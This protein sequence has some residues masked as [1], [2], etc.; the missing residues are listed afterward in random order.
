MSQ[1]TNA[2]TCHVEWSERSAFSSTCEEKIS[3]LWLEMANA[4]QSPSG[5]QTSSSEAQRSGFAG[6]HRRAVGIVD[7][8][9]AVFFQHGFDSIRVANRD[10]LQRI[11]I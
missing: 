5:K 9:R 4:T 2:H 1:C 6:T 8:H 10:H 3:R 11:G 7:F